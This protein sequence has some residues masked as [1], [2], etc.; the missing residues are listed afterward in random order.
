MLFVLFLVPCAVLASGSV[1]TNPLGESS[2]EKI[3]GRLIKAVLGLS[4]TAAL[5]MFVYGGILMVL[6][7]GAKEK[8]TKAKDTLKWAVFG[9]AFVFISY[10][11]LD[12]IITLLQ[13]T[14]S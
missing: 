8:V 3:V 10:T 13:K 9:L 2:I 4:G 14:A 6:S 12:T 5:A 11:V 7:Q 1:L